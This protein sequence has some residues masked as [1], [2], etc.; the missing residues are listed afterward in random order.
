MA[1]GMVKWFNEKK[2]YGFITAEDQ[3]DLFV[4]Y[5]AI[6]G[7]GFKS[8]QEGDHVSFEIEQGRKGPSAVRV[9]KL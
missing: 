4:H 7:S 5:S 1:Q 3:K 2:G 9:K 6:E 8:L